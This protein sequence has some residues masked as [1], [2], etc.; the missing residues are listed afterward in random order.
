M[1][2]KYLIT[3][4]PLEPFFFGGEYTFGADD[5]RSKDSR[6]SATSTYFPQQSALLG[7]LR[8]TL[9]IQEGCLTLHRKGEWVDGSRS[10]K[11]SMV[12]GKGQFSYD[13]DYDIGKIKSLSPLFITQNKN[14]YI[15]NAK[16]ATFS[17]KISSTST[18]L[19]GGCEQPN[20]VFEDYDPKSCSNNH[21]IS[22]DGQGIKTLDDFYT[23][24]SNVG[25]KKSTN[26]EGEEDAFFQKTSFSLN[27][28]AVF[29]C[30]LE[31]EEPVGLN[32]TIVTLG[33]D[34]S[35]FMMGVKPF[36]KDFD[37]LFKAAF[38]AK[39]LDRVVLTSE[40]LVSSE[41]S[42]D[43][44]FILGERKSY[45]FL[46]SEKNAASKGK[47]S[48]RYFLLDRGSVIYT[49]NM[50]KLV[51]HLSQSHLQRVGINHFIALKGA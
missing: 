51:S 1:S 17:P 31:L 16:D 47:K 44:L 42:Q 41:A 50:D 3:L 46:K 35:S 45:R 43:A 19:L 29:A 30:I 23:D 9:L 2:Q 22:H 49:N 33:A 36:D 39:S 20:I 15:A 8:R 14:F 11:A 5:S 13:E 10:S 48:K 18:M 34:Q 40:T 12:A 26:G 7:M 6:Y 21:F 24:I 38:G 32:E 28:N 25:I 37:E 4:K 27:N